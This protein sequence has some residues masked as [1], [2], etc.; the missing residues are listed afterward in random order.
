MCGHATELTISQGLETSTP[1]LKLGNQV[2]HGKVT[3]PIGDEVILSRERSQYACIIVHD[4]I[5]LSISC[6]AKAPLTA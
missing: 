3:D 2:Y 4:A 6:Q 5:W 1:F